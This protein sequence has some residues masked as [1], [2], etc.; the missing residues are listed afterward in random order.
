MFS[1][2]IEEAA[3]VSISHNGVCITV[4]KKLRNAYTVTGIKETL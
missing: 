4:V 3:C 2:I 1:G